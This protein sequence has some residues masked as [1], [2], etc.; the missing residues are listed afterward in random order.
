MSRPKKKMLPVLGQEPNPQDTPH[1]EAP[2][3]DAANPTSV[4]GIER[5]VLSV[6]AQVAMSP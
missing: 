2:V 6:T 3:R 4:D 1:G 5:T